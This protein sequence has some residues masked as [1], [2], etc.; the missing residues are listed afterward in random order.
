M[1]QW[2]GGLSKGGLGGVNISAVACLMM[3]CLMVRDYII[4]KCLL[5][6]R[7]QMVT[8]NFSVS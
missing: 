5:V 3:W 8:E 1:E 2:S 6:T 4:S 7:E